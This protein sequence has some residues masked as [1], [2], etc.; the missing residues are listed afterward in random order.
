M[1][2]LELDPVLV[3]P[4]R[5]PE[6]RPRRKKKARVSPA[7]T[8]TRNL[9]LA[10][11][12]GTIGVTLIGRVAAFAV[13]PMVDTWRTGTE[14]RSLESQ[15]ARQKEVNDRLRRDID[16]IRT[17]AGTEQE[18]RRRGWVKDGEVALSVVVPEPLPDTPKPDLTP[19][20]T[21]A[22]PSV[23]ARIQSAIDTCLAVFGGSRPR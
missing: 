6:T 2:Q 20:Q 22:A 3:T 11:V 15:V 23:S 21:A 13:G 12:V 14:I 17:P 9:A 8:R 5:R 18:A 1:S 10:L 19:V 7:D 4:L 16:Y